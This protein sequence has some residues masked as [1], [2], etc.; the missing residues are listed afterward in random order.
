MHILSVPDSIPLGFMTLQPGRY[1]LEDRNGA[2]LMLRSPGTSLTVAPQT[3]PL[4]SFSSRILLVATMG[5]GDALLLTPCLR[6]IKASLPAATLHI[7]TFPEYR[8]IFFG[9]PYVDGFADYPVPTEKLEEYDCVLI[10]EG[11]V[12]NHPQAQ[13]QHMTD[14]FAEHLGLAL[15]DKKPDLRLSSEELE[16]VMAS[17]PKKP[18]EKRIGIQV[19]AGVRCRTYPGSHLNLLANGLAQAGWE[20]YL[21]GRPGEFA[22][23][24]QGRIHNLSRRALTWRQ[25]AAFL[26]TCD[27][28][29]G[30]DSSLLHAAGALDVPAVG[31]FGPYPWKLRTAYYTTV[32][33]IQGSE[34][35]D[36]HPCFHV[37]HAGLPPFPM[38]QPCARSGRCEVLASIL[39]KRVIAKIEQ[40]AASS[41]AGLPQPAPLGESQ[42]PPSQ[43]SPPH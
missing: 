17:F 7:A 31:L 13:I 25:S 4:N 32:F 43:D 18:A 10:L 42:A 30:P 36:R 14:R 35:C 15:G 21:M 23:Q 38:D 3:H 26:K 9:L 34:G 1:F 5:F 22:A 40:V 24:D 16:W 12:E 33:C 27:V 8:Q 19:Q 28:F 6:Q 11:A 2:E 20:V 39:P 41:K 29:V 37:E